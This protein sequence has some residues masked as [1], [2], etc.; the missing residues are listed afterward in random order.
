MQTETATTRYV[1][2]DM[3][4]AETVLAELVSGQ[5]R[6]IAAVRSAI[7]HDAASATGRR[8]RV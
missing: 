2:M 7:G 3:W 5:E 8:L 4:P 1:G 6:A